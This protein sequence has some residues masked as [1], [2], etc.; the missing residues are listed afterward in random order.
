MDYFPSDY[1]TI[2]DESHMTLPQIRAMFNGD[3][4]RKTNL[5]DYGF[6]VEAAF[7]N[8]PLN[9]DEFNKKL[10]QTIYISATPS[11]YELVPEAMCPIFIFFI[12]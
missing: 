7:D 11:N 6:R 9:F 8:R 4:A 12:R 1:V 3:R 5:V 10:G 2:I